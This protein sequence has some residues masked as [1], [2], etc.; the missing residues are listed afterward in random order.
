MLE[1]LSARFCIDCG[2]RDPIILEFDHIVRKD[3]KK[4]VSKMLSGHYSWE[5]VLVEIKKCEIRCANCHRRKTYS[6]LKYWG[7]TPS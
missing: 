2:E 4:Q 1:Y 5:K 6:Q 7:R 3:K